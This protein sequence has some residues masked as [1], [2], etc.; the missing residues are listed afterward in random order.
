MKTINKVVFGAAM[1]ILTIHLLPSRSLAEGLA[2]GEIPVFCSS[3]EA[4]QSFLDGRE[5]Y[6]MGR[7]K[8]ATALF[9]KA[10]IKYPEFASA[11]LYKAYSSKTE[12]EW[13]FNMEKALKYSLKSNE[14]ERMLIELEAIPK[15]ND[16]VRLEMAK[17]LVAFF[18][19]STRAQLILAKEY[20]LKGE[21]T[22]FRDLATNI[23][24]QNTESPLGYRA[25]ASSYL[26]NE[27]I[28]FELALKYMKK[29]VELRPNEAT[30]HIALGDVY[31]ANMSLLEASEEYSKAIEIDPS[32]VIAFSKR[33]YQNSYMGRFDN[34]RNDFE[35]SAKLSGNNSNLSW[36]NNSVVSYL[37]AGNSNLG[38]ITNQQVNN[39][40]KIS[41]KENIPLESPTEEHY[42][43]CSVIAMIHGIYT[44]VSKSLN[45]CQSL[46]KELLQESVVPE[47]H[48]IDANFA[49]IE[50]IRALSNQDYKNATQKA[51][52]HARLLM[53]D[54]NPEKLQVYNYLMGL[55]NLK[56]QNYTKAIKYYLKSDLSNTCVKYEL[57]LAYDGA[58]KFE[59]AKKV[60]LDVADCQFKSFSKLLM[61]KKADEWL[62][63]YASII[64]TTNE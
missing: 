33:G 6:E 57:G 31:R 34:A 1:V 51:E 52:E 18:P 19:E 12:A 38:L 8:D 49:F 37:F 25:L 35:M 23:I 3:N 29:F 36:P 48:A 32:S 62:N 47:Q 20:Q 27:P 26:L 11:Y 53:P 10:L 39:K 46:Q 4:L 43:C 14:G 64:N 58:G 30:A 63:I 59:E 60:L 41:K 17:K 61:S 44:G 24:H 56:Q 15:G 55:I 45:E 28:D 2:K 22:K 50:A 7:I 13:A 16:K 40:E 9:D 5:A 54:L 42:F 21:N